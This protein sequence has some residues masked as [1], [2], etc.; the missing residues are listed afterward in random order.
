MIAYLIRHAKTHRDS[1]TGRDADRVLKERGHRQAL[2]LAA[3]LRDAAPMRPG[4]LRSSPW[5][6]AVQTSE[7]IWEALSLEATIEPRL[8]GDR[9]VR[10]ML[11]V[12]HDGRGLGAAAI[13]SHNMVVSRLVDVIVGG[14]GAGFDHVLRTG[15]IYAIELTPGAAPDDLLGAGRV[16]ETFRHDG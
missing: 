12:I 6:R 2:A 11:G 15:E 3:Y 13:V 4:A 7:P 14:A 16:I 10:E 5:R 8:A 9:S 1:E